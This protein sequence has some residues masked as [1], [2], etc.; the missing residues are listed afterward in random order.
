MGENILRSR[1]Q[2]GEKQV[3]SNENKQTEKTEKEDASKTLGDISD[4]KN[5]PATSF[6]PSSHTRAIEEF[7]FHY[8]ENTIEYP[9][10]QRNPVWSEKDQSELIES[11]IRGIPIPPIYINTYTQNGK[12]IWEVLDG[13]QRITALI[14]FFRHNTVKINS[15]LPKEYKALQNY[16]Y[17][18]IVEANPLFAGK[19]TAIQLPVISLDNAPD[20]L[21]NE[22]FQKLNKGGKTLT[23]GELA[24][25]SLGPASDFMVQLMQ[26]EFYTKNVHKTARYAQYV[27]ASRILHFMLQAIQKDKTFQY[28]SGGRYNWKNKIT[29]ETRNI[30]TDLDNLHNDGS[31]KPEEQIVPSL[32]EETNRVSELIDTIFGDIESEYL[33]NKLITNMVISLLILEDPSDAQAMSHDDLKTSYKGLV[34]FWEKGHAPLLRQKMK[35]QMSNITNDEELLINECNKLESQSKEALADVLESIRMNTYSEYV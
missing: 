15:N 2:K 21:K 22:F 3:M 20:D 5:L 23:S 1:T 13:R 25:S 17:K 16:K 35:T 32:K 8:D 33:N 9:A 24:H 26:T 34:K 31:K 6:Q 28:N 30:Q 11:L 7:L 19:F 18:Q 12:Q 14:G 10:M 27:P 29:K 4:I